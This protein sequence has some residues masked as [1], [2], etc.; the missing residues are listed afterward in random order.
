MNFEELGS[1]DTFSLFLYLTLRHFGVAWST[2]AII[3]H[4]LDCLIL[5]L[6]LFPANKEEMAKEQSWKKKMRDFN[7]PVCI[8]SAVRKDMSQSEKT[9]LPF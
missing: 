3:I 6:S 5:S 8:I 4:W 2:H 7:T 9:H 1:L